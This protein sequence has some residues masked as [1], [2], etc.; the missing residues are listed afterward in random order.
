MLRECDLNS[1][2]IHGTRGNNSVFIFEHD[3]NATLY[4]FRLENLTNLTNLNP[5]Y[6]LCLSGE[7]KDSCKFVSFVFV[8][9]EKQAQVLT[10][11]FYKCNKSCLCRSYYP[12]VSVR[13]RTDKESLC[14]SSDVP[15]QLVANPTG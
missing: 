8:F 6:S 2:G 11:K 5:L 14:V 1:R 15:F 7:Q 3:C 10:K 13:I 12:C 4:T 9:C